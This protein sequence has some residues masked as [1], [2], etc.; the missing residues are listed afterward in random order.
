MTMT[1]CSENVL[2]RDDFDAGLAIS[3]LWLRRKRLEAVVKIARD[4]KGYHKWQFY[5]SLT[6]SII[7]E[8]V[9]YLGK[10]YVAKKPLENILSGYTL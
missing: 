8:K 6:M 9:V 1:A 7:V 2:C 10:S 4:E 5:F 3:F